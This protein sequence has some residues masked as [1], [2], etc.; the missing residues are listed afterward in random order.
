VRICHFQ[1]HAIRAAVVPIVELVGEDGRIFPLWL[2]CCWLV[3][4]QAEAMRGV[5]GIPLAAANDIFVASLLKLGIL[6][7]SSTLKVEK[8]EFLHQQIHKGRIV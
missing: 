7:I 1:D 4:I 8:I 3:G 5:V 6:L 2:L